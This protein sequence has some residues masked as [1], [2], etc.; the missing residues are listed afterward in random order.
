MLAMT[1]F[2]NTGHTGIPKALA[3][4]ASEDDFKQAI[5]WGLAVRLC[6]KLTGGAEQALEQTAL[7][8]VDGRLLLEFREPMLALA[9][10]SVTKNL[11]I[12]AEWLGL[13][14]SIE[15]VSDGRARL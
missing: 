5:A 10:N 9:S 7:K 14:W 6:R 13:D 12:L 2:A 8:R 11:R 1:V 15:T 4:L 3:L